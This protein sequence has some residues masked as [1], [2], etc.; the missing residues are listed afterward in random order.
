[1]ALKSDKCQK[2]PE[3]DD[4][5]QNLAETGNWVLQIG[6]KALSKAVTCDLGVEW[7]QGAR[8]VT[9]YSP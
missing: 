6:K 8:H 4:V 7:E 2:D 5:L 9:D 3:A 1:M